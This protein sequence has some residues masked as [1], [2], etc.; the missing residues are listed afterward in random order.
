[1]TLFRYKKNG[2]LYTVQHVRDKMGLRYE[3]HPYKHTVYIGNQRPGK[4]LPK[5]VVFKGNMFLSDFNPV[6]EC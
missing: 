3:A 1:M 5:G 6:A 2:L 4:Y